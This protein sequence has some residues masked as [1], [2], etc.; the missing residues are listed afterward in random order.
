[1]ETHSMER[2]SCRSI[3]IH[4]NQLVDLQ[5]MEEGHVPQAW[6]DAIIVTIYNK[7]EK[8]AC[9]NYPGISHLT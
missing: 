2:H 9:G 6:K 3:E 5:N 7:G 4:G 1:M 8:T